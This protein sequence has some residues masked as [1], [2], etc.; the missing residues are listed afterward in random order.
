MHHIIAIITIGI[1][2][3]DLLFIVITGKGIFTFFYERQNRGH[4][5]FVAVI[6]TPQSKTSFI[7]SYVFRSV[8]SRVCMQ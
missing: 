7:F 4:V 2:S 3:N 1:C 5:H 6:I 8:K